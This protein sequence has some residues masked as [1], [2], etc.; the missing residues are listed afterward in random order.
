M[1]VQLEVE[2]DT[3]L[4]EAETPQ[5]KQGANEY[6]KEKPPRTVFTGYSL[7]KNPGPSRKLIVSQVVGARE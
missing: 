5:P 6:S 7:K 4:E 1:G 2:T 3:S